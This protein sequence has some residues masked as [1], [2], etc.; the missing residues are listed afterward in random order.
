MLELLLAGLIPLQHFNTRQVG[1]KIAKS[2]SSGFVD[3][4]CAE[5][6]IATPLHHIY[7]ENYIGC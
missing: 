7:F 5:V 4:G 3:R 6:L 1:F 2:L